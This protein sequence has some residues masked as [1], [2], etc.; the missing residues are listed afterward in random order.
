MNIIIV[1][2]AGYIGSVVSRKLYDEGHKIRII[3]RNIFLSDVDHCDNFTNLDIRDLEIEHFE[4]ADIVLDYSGL[5]ND[6]S[7]DISEELT[8]DI[9]I[10]GRKRIAECAKAAGV[11]R[12]V[13]A[14]TCSVYGT[15]ESR[16]T[17]DENHMVKP[18]TTY[19]RS[20]AEMEKNLLAM[21]SSAFQILCIRH[22][23]VYG[24][25]PKMRLDLVV[26]LM[27]KNALEKRRIYVT[28]GGNQRR[29]LLSLNSIAKFL[30]LVV[31]REDNFI[32]DDDFSVV[33]LAE[34]NVR[35]SDLAYRLSKIMKDYSGEAI[36]TI[37]VPDDND[38]RDYSVS[39][40][41]MRNF[42]EFEPEYLQ[43]E[44]MIEL[45]NGL[46][47]IDFTDPRYVTQKWYRYILGLETNIN[48]AGKLCR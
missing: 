11:K 12:Y 13:F 33:N 37:I 40:A 2:G 5:S 4:H 23:T 39:V 6:P 32:P 7:G 18:L 41:K 19:A 8:T 34:G 16:V 27:C 31:C 28:G 14:S 21:S 26:N 44:V 48:L 25:S 36:E 30:S 46:R 42:Y 1:G 20:A 9:N 47:T 17:V 22:G 38:K 43:D 10:N 24:F 35:M 15:V 45:I 3:D 29:P